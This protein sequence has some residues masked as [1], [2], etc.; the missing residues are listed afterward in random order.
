MAEI[1]TIGEILVEVMAKE[2]GQKFTETGE[3]QGPFPSG[4]P[5][6]FI[7]Q[8]AK[9]GSS[10]RILSKVGDDGFGRINVNRLKEDGVD[11][12]HIGRLP[13]RTTG[14]AF[15]TYKWDGG[16]EFIYTI[17]E[18]ASAFI[19]R[20][21]LSEEL[22]EGCKYLHIAGC[23]AFN[24]EMMSLLRKSII[25]AKQKNI[26][27]SFDPNIRQELMENRAMKQFVLFAL[28]NCDIFL[29]GQEELRF[30]T[31]NDD[32]ESAVRAI[33]D[34]KAACV[35]V[36]RGSKGCRVYEKDR[37][38]DLAAH[39]VKEV[40]PTGAGDCFAGAFVSLLNQ[41]WSIEEA[42]KYANA[43]GAL[44]VTK[45]GPMEGTVSLE[46]IACFVAGRA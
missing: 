4:A 25:I 18:S 44:S 30:I 42:A 40:D 7:D 34:E 38:Y 22:F 8:A 13:D 23:S 6:I 19:S 1:L 35:V 3:F 16:R 28:D 12:S 41:G 36:K 20:D 26:Q 43:A 32:E 31:G 27:I 11:V 2:V 37:Y 9:L 17:K 33:L 21:D 15:V 24:N 46:E 45:R 10:S 29:P 14:I 39:E 5:A